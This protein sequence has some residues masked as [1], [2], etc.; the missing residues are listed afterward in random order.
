MRR[1]PRV[2]LAMTTAVLAVACSSDGAVSG[3]PVEEGGLAVYVA[4]A[5]E[6]L[7]TIEVAEALFEVLDL[8]EEA[9]PKTAGLYEARID[10]TGHRGVVRDRRAGSISIS[11][12]GP[13]FENQGCSECAPLDATDDVDAL[14]VRSEE[15]LDAIGVDTSTVVLSEGVHTDVEHRILG[16]VV[17]A[18][19]VVDDLQFRFLWG[20]DAELNRFI[21]RRY[22]I[23]TIGTVA[24][25]DEGAALA[26]AESMIGDNL[27]ITGFELQYTG[28]FRD[29]EL[30]LAPSFIATTDLGTTFSVPA[31][32]GPLPR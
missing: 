18:G 1:S 14:F 11:Y 16:D 28:A 26:Q 2:L 5:P 9:A 23:E 17:I 3:P 27:E 7:E 29:G 19:A 12:S 8:P 4:G 13:K 32:A 21:G 20:H 6:G 15:I 24:P 25:R 10:G 22:E 31:F 30:V